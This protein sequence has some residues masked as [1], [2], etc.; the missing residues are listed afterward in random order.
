MASFRSK[1]GSLISTR[2]M[3][4]TD[5]PFLLDIFEHMGP[6]SRYRRFHQTLEH[7]SD[8][9]IRQEAALI[10]QA[11]L[12]HNAGILAFAHLPGEGEVAIGMARFVRLN[13]EEAEVAISL[14]DDMQRQGIGTQL[15]RMAAEEARAR[16]YKRLVAMIQ[17][18]NPGIWS[19]FNRLPYQVLRR[20]EDGTHSNIVVVLTAP[21]QA[22]NKPPS[23]VQ[24][25]Y[26]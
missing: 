2:L 25:T 21:R 17:N 9:R 24:E 10:A 5:V 1:S 15:M 7:V 23:R 19:V 18:D 4:A 22:A 26:S 6:D 20:P 14:R 13:D 12:T 3:Q 8:E 11:D 16:G